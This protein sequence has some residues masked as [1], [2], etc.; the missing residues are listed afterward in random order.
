VVLVLSPHR[1]RCN[2]AR[3]ARVLQKGNHNDSNH[4]DALS[5]RLVSNSKG[6]SRV[7]FFSSRSICALAGP[8]NGWESP[9]K[10]P[11]LTRP[12][13]PG[14]FRII[15]EI[16]NIFGVQV[17][18]FGAR[19]TESGGL[20]RSAPKANRKLGTAVASVEELPICITDR[21]RPNTDFFGGRTVNVRNHDGLVN[22]RALDCNGVRNRRFR[23]GI[24]GL[25]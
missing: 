21:V 7:Y 16:G 5:S 24:D 22:R 18:L 17:F 23:I 8:L 19:Q 12:F 11:E 25:P 10:L 6:S 20:R 1:I 13:R 9:F 14:T 2:R 15:L 4:Q 3:S